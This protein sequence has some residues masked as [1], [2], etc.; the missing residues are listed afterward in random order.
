MAAGGGM[1]GVAVFA[2]IVVLMALAVLGR[3]EARFERK[4]GI[5]TYEVMGPSAEVVLEELNR[6]AREQK[7]EFHDFHAATSGSASRIV[8]SAPGIAAGDDALNV[9]LHRSNIFSSVQLIGTELPE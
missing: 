6:V 3:L 8:F 5:L 4:R 2:T 7:L 1:Y 9:A